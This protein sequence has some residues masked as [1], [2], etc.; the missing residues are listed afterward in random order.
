MTTERIRLGEFDIFG[1]REGYFLLDGGAMFGVVPKTLWEK[2]CPAD[3]KNR[4]RLG[5]N[6]LVIKTPR[7]LVLVETGIGTKTDQKFAGIYCVETEPG[8]VPA[9]AGAGFRPEEVDFVINTH[10]HFDHCGG[11]TRLDESGRIVPTFPRAR[12]IIQQGEWEAAVRPNER[13]RRSYFAENF[14]PLREAGLVDLVDGDREV[15]PGVE[16]VVTPG[17]T[18]RHQS[19]RVRSGGRTLDFLGD[20]VPTA[21]HVRLSYIMS[22]DLYPLE[23]LETRKKLYEEAIAGDWILG[24][25]HDPVHFFGRVRKTDSR[26]E[27]VPV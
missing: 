25:V 24:F 1:L 22:Y 5:L 21:A 3:A 20:L 2:A 8:L 16:V 27:F 13:D 12:Y 7:A 15:T 18:R 11:N 9:L 19:V 10:L 14:L 26:Y 17:H 6:S 23:T 4:I